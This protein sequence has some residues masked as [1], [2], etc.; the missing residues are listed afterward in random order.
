MSVIIPPIIPALP[1]SGHLSSY[2]PSVREVILTLLIAL[3]AVSAL[4]FLFV[5]VADW[6][7][8]HSTTHETLLHHIGRSLATIG[9]LL[10]DLW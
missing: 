3:A 7:W 6:A 4:V 8:D 10:K 5:N 9:E 2:D 1:P